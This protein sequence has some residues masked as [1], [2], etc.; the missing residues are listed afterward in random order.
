MPRSVVLA[1]VFTV[2]LIRPVSHAWADDND[3]PRPENNTP[4]V[5]QN[6]TEQN[7]R[8]STSRSSGLPNP[9]RDARDRIY[10]PGDTERAKPLAKKLVANVLLDQKEIWLSPFH[11]RKQDSKWWV[12]FGAVTAALIATDHKTSTALENS[13][14]QVSWGNGLSNRGG[15]YAYPHHGRIL[16]SWSLGKQCAGARNRRPRSRSF[17]GQPH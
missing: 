10:Y 4:V 6:Q 16:W 15:I 9:F 1:L 14:G 11:M 13:P 5:A 8:D 3:G 7:D 17:A 12:G 2:G